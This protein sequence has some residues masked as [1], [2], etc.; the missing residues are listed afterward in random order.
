MIRE[1]LHGYAACISGSI[2]KVFE[3]DEDMHV[4]RMLGEHLGCGVPLL[5]DS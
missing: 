2:N 4:T 3:V 1:H 5:W